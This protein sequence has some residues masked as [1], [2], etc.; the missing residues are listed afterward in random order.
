MYTARRRL[1]RLKRRAFFW[2]G[3]CV[4]LAAA[5]LYFAMTPG[6]PCWIVGLDLMGTAVSIVGA[7]A[8]GVTL[9][10]LPRG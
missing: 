7:V 4:A 10:R 3:F 9:W 2:G 1:H 8:T 5:N 6:M